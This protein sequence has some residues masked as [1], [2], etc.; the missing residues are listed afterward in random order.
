MT[1][2]TTV[3]AESFDLPRPAKIETIPLNGGRCVI[4]GESL[5]KT[6]AAIRRQTREPEEKEVIGTQMSLF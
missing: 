3:I 1:T 5:T 6:Q 4:T 2:L